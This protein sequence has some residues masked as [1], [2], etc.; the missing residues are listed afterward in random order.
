MAELVS[1]TIDNQTVSVPA[2]TLIVDAA[3]KVGV[4][5]PVFCYHPKME[6]VG[7]CRMCLVEIGR[8]LRDRVSGEYIKN[9]DGS[10]KVSF[11]P[12]LETACTTPVSDGMV[13]K[14]DTQT[15]K[16]G[17]EGMLEFILTSH[18]LDCP[19]C[20]KGGECPLQNL[21][22]AHGP[23]ESRFDYADKKH[24]AKHVPLGELIY[25]DRE[26]CI[27]CARCVRF[28]H[29]IV[30]DPVINFFHRGRS[31]EIRTFSEPGFDSIFSGNTTDICPVG[32]LTT[33]D[34]RF[35]ARPWEMEKVSSICTQCSVGCNLAM[36]IRR[37]A[38]SGGKSVIKRIMPRQNEQVNE[39]W[40]CD[41][42]RLGYHF[43]DSERRITQPH[44]RKDGMLVPTTWEE[45][46]R[47]VEDRL[48]VEN[49][50][51]V[52]LVGGRLANEDL[53][54][55][56]QLTQLKLGKPVLYSQMSG[57]D[58]TS[59]IGLGVGSNF[60]EM[61]KGTVIL[62]IASDVHQEAP[63]FWLRIKQAANRGATLIVAG[64]RPTRLEKY[65][66]HVVRYNYGEEASTLSAFM[67]GAE[68]KT[69]MQDSVSAFVNAENG[70]V[71][72]GNDGLGL[73]GSEHLAKACARLV[74][75]YG[76]YGK[77]NNGLLAVWDQANT[78]GAWDMGFH[79]DRNLK[80]TIREADVLM[81]AG[82]D[83]AGD[84][85]ILAD[86]MKDTDFVVVFELFMTES[87]RLADVV[88][89]V[90]AQ[91]EREGS[92]TSAE[93]RVQRFN[94]VLLRQDGPRTDS[95]IVA[96][97]ARQLGLHLEEASPVLIMKQIAE[98]IPAYQGITFTGLAKVIE[99]W[100]L[101]GREDLYFAGT[102]Y[103][104]EDGLGIQYPSGSERGEELSLGAL[105]MSDPAQ[106]IS[107]G[108]RVVPVTALY[109]HG[110]MLKDTDLLA[111]RLAPQ[112]LI[113]HPKL[114]ESFSLT[115]TDRIIISGQGWEM[116]GGV[117]LDETLPE[118][119]ALV[120]RSSGFPIHAPV[121]VQ[122]QRLVL[123]PEA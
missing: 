91:P 51:L 60:G 87:A 36:N 5:I 88:F 47:R 16:D 89:P 43:V 41:K 45:A 35:G 99:Q 75:E 118:E 63:L 56:A 95:S 24:L 114:A 120:A 113:M 84:D 64:A 11:G 110:Q 119:T 83:P 100:P 80:G 21:T 81:V 85:P 67:K 115:S 4:D 27:Q 72:Y 53:F 102:S 116:E 104:N 19:I 20:D 59:Q 121:F 90:L 30:D 44:V 76:F 55:F 26:R 54:N 6:P 7:M 32:A 12:K 15:A 57:G 13:V 28:Q 3:K 52:S 69:S 66:S 77:K 82:A 122:V 94:T 23:G 48:R 74:V 46:F 29:D 73:I 18:P 25:L 111:Q 98:K 71:I 39:I 2:G 117:V 22:M 96:Q 61:G 106:E 123:T 68:D 109:D 70:V 112:A 97:I 14:T 10:L 9:E 93:R 34:F 42:G 103:E 31:L 33:A 40:I 49:T 78:Q 65:A 58:L 62:V 37:E 50:R 105:I 38:I 8:P 107:S 79:P 17:R 86:S 101:M 108:I 92:F 1:L